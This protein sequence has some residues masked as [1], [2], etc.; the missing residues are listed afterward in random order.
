MKERR[1]RKRGPVDPERVRRMLEL[2]KA[3]KTYESIGAEFGVSASTVHTLLQRHGR[4]V[5]RHAAA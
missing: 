4:M 3:N 2:R 5:A 1:G